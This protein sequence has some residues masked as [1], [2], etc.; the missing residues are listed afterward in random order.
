MKVDREQRPA[1]P[2]LLLV[3]KRFFFKDQASAQM[4]SLWQ[5]S[6]QVV[7]FEELL[8]LDSV[9]VEVGWD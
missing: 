4:T 9:V 5:D 1:G 8:V 7:V 3:F 6:S 2:E